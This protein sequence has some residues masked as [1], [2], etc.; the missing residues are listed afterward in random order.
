MGTRLQNGKR[1]Y[2]HNIMPELHEI[3]T[4]A[5]KVSKH[6]NYDNNFYSF[7]VIIFV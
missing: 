4:Y 1:F 6:N 5:M 3:R 7:P 2:T